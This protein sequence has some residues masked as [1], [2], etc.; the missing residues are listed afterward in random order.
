MTAL[1]GRTPDRVPL[2]LLVPFHG[3]IREVLPECRGR[4]FIL[5]PSA[6][7]YEETIDERVRENYLAFLQA[8]WDD[9]V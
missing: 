3:Q 4:R 6:G 9:G 5:S 1:D 7:P 2:W 8:G